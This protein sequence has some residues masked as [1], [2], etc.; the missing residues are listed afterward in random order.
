[1]QKFHCTLPS[2]ADF[3]HY[4]VQKFKFGGVHACLSGTIWAPDAI[5]WHFSL[6][7][8]RKDRHVII[9]VNL[10]LSCRPR[11]NGESDAVQGTRALTGRFSYGMIAGNAC[12]V[13]IGGREATYF[14]R[15]TVKSLPVIKLRQANMAQAG[16]P[17]RLPVQTLPLLK[18]P[19]H[20]E[21]MH[22]SVGCPA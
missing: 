8:V 7:R 5:S 13:M 14:Y 19:H 3:H 16:D 6:T 17:C 15:H 4:R 20:V 10:R 11:E 18:P 22:T 9:V 12:V 1:M 21:Q 2:L